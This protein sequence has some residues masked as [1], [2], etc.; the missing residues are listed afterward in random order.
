MC[1]RGEE[2]KDVVKYA[3]TPYPG[4]NKVEISFVSALVAVVRWQP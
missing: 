1:R 3:V 2:G 4:V